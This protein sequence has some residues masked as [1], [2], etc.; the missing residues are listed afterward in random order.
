MET[1]IFPFDTLNIGAV[2]LL[3]ESNIN[4]DKKYSTH[5]ETILHLASRRNT[6]DIV[7]Y[8]VDNGADIGAT[9]K[10]GGTP[11]FDAACSGNID[12]VKYLLDQG[13][14]KFVKN[15]E[16]MTVM[17]KLHRDGPRFGIAEYID[18]FEAVPTKGVHMG[19]GE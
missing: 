4:L 14:D 1:A 10:Y 5:K 16:N 15:L 9:D 18:E 12:I 7:K 17:D 3:V 13:A 19:P 2:K 6:L 11:L 8:L